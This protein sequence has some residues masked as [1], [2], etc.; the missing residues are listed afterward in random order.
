MN[1]WDIMQ[2]IVETIL[3]AFLVAM[4]VPAICALGFVVWM[5]WGMLLMVLGVWQP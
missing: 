1:D 5:A 3:K 4:A 2:K